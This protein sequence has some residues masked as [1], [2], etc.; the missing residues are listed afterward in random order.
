M[1][2]KHILAMKGRCVMNNKLTAYVGT[3]TNGD[4]KGIY[5]LVMN[6][7]DGKIEEVKLAAELENPTYLTISSDNKYLYSVIKIGDMGGVAAF[8]IDPVSGD[9]KLINSQ[10]AKG[11]APCH[12]SLDSENKYLFSANYHR[13][14]VEV[15]PIG[16]RGELNPPGSIMIHEGSGPN[17]DRQETPHVHYATLTPD[18]KYLCAVD[19]G[20]DKLVVYNCKNGILSGGEEHSVALNPGCGP[21]HMTFHPNGKFAYVNTELSNEIVILEYN[22]LGHG[23]KEIGYIS[24]LPEEYAGK[25]FG[26]AIHISKDGKYLYS[27]NRGHDSIAVFSIEGSSGRLQRIQYI[28]TEGSFPRDFEIDPTGSFILASNQ[29]SNNI[30]TFAIDRTSGK[31]LRTG[32][33]VSVPNPVCIKFL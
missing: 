10:V 15:Y 4:S 24:T 13:G 20:I 2:G 7:E 28:P 16:E 12:V 3:Y 9:L 27:A 6:A 33:E 32:N 22:V 17:K 23:F 21:R 11:S 29:D 31:L 25:S 14:L 18:E 5:R 30:L 19:L 8:S 1:G 26:S